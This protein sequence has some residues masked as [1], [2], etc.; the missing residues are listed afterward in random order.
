MPWRGAKIGAARDVDVPRR[1]AAS[2][3]SSNRAVGQRPACPGAANARLQRR[4]IRRRLLEVGVGFGEFTPRRRA[5]PAVAV[6]AVSP[7]APT[8]YVA[9]SAIRRNAASAANRDLHPATR[10]LAVE[11]ASREGWRKLRCRAC[12]D[13]ADRRPAASGARALRIRIARRRA[14]P[15][16]RVSPPLRLE[17]DARVGPGSRRGKRLRRGCPRD[18]P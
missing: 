14:V 10:L 4:P 3:A 11:D 5:G 13:R 2:P 15:R 17:L 6:A 7:V 12:I 9:S 1:S 16:G 18:R 8:R